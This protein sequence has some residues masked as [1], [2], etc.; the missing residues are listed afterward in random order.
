MI[1]GSLVFK[2]SSGGYFAMRMGNVV[3]IFELVAV[4]LCSILQ[5]GVQC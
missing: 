2:I 5:F 3:G 4:H 1:Y